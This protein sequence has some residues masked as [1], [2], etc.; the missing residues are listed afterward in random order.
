MDK[1]VLIAGASGVIGQ[2]L[3]QFFK[4]QSWTII[5][6]SHHKKHP[7]IPGVKILYWNPK[8]ILSSSHNQELISAM[9]SANCVINLAG[10]AIS[11]GRLGRKHRDKILQTRLDASNALVKLFQSAN[12]KPSLWIQASATGYYG[13]T[14]N[15]EIDESGTL[16][17]R[18]LSS[19]CHHWENCLKPIETNAENTRIIIARIGLVF[20]DD[21]PAWQR[22]YLPI[23]WGFGGRLGKGTQWWSWIHID[24][25]VRA[26]Y[27]FI[28][29]KTS[30]IYNLTTPHPTQQTHLV[31]QIAKHIKRPTFFPSPAFILKLTLGKL[32]EEL[33][34]NS[35]K[36]LPKRLLEE[37]FT[38]KYPTIEKMIPKLLD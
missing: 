33:I 15:T 3:I 38:Y 34:L 35:A 25:L 13:D 23:K 1:T 4:K 24:D 21:A 37:R 8:S 5:T 30:G 9:T 14:K 10:S 29:S 7:N 11:N 32:A 17:K 27:H 19:V 16:G 12:Q 6:F 26:F 2:H 36:I 20:A 22:L 31:E 28:E 18:F